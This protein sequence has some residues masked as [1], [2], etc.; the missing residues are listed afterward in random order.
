MSDSGPQGL[1]AGD[2]RAEG[3]RLQAGNSTVKSWRQEQART[4]GEAAQILQRSVQTT[5][6]AKT[7]GLQVARKEREEEKVEGQRSPPPQPAPLPT[8]WLSTGLQLKDEAMSSRGRGS[9][10]TGRELDPNVPLE[11]GS[12][13]SEASFPGA[14]LHKDNKLSQGPSGSRPLEEA[15]MG[16]S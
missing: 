14:S 15:D 16:G 3:G 8:G 2:R 5:K 1:G 11:T 13:R 10:M 7:M 12:V 9:L 4:F 6:V